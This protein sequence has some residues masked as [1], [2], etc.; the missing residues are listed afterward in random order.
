M[1]WDVGTRKRLPQDP[2]QVKE[3]D[4]ASIAFS[5][6]GRTLAAGFGL[7]LAVGFGFENSGGVVLWDV[8]TRKRLGEDPLAPKLGEVSSVAFSPDGKALAAKH[9]AGMVLWDVAT[10][11]RLP[12]C[13]LVVG[14]AEFSSF[15]FSP[16]G[17]TLATGHGKSLV[18]LDLG[19]DSLRRPAGLRANRNFTR[20]EWREYFPE[21]P[22]RAT[23]PDLPIPPEEAPK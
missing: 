20:K 14:E 10:R 23:F 22:Y 19:L 4:V 18:L 3:G 9:S 2:L 15:A 6:D 12:Q 13:P 1:L 16:D 21:T 17:K 7:T 8:A 11:K 5:P